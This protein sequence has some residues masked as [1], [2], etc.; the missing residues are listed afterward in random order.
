MGLGG[1]VVAG[2]AAGCGARAGVQHGGVDPAAVADAG[3]P[4]CHPLGGQPVGAVLVVERVR[5]ARLIGESSSANSPTA[6]GKA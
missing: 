3:Q 6:P 4:G 2:R 5:N 1:A